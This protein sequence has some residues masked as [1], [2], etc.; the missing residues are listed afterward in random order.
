[1]GNSRHR[2]YASPWDDR[3]WFLL[4]SSE[5]LRGCRETP[6]RNRYALYKHKSEV[7]KLWENTTE[8]SRNGAETQQRNCETVEKT[9]QRNRETGGKHHG[10]IVKLRGNAKVEWLNTG[11]TPQW[12]GET[13]GKRESEMAKQCGNAKAKL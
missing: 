10:E 11:E 1:M 6:R 12:I 5:T 8:K 3:L 9:Q 4:D 7:V 13:L 2:E